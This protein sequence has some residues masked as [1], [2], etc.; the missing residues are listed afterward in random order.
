MKKMYILTVLIIVVLTIGFLLFFGDENTINKRFL[1]TYKIK[2][3]D[4]PCIVEEIEIP[5]EFTDYYESYNV[6]QIESGLTLSPYKGKK[7]TKYTYQ[8]LNFPQKTDVPVYVNVI[9][10]DSKPIAGDINCPSLSGFI[11]PLSYL[12]KK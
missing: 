3:S 11:L 7:A 10:I 8:M 4:K 2:V 12:L 6:L 5:L 9:T 1:S